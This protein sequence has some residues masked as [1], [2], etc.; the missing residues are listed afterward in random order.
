MS[1]LVHNSTKRV[2]ARLLGRVKE[3]LEAFIAPTDSFSINS[4]APLS[5]CYNLVELNLSLVCSPLPFVRLKKA[6]RHLD[7]LEYL[8]LPT[9]TTILVEESAD[10]PW[11]PRLRHLRLSGSFPKD[12]MEFFSWPERQSSLTLIWCND[13]SVNSISSLIC[14]RHLGRQLKHLEISPENRILQPGSINAVPRF[15]PNLRSLVVPGNLLQDDFFNNL[16][17]TPLSLEYLAIEKSTTIFHSLGFSERSL[18]SALDYGLSNLQSVLFDP[19]YSGF[20]SSGIFNSISDAL[21]AQWKRRSPGEFAS[22]EFE[23]GVFI[24]DRDECSEFVF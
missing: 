22:R 1:W 4:L 17:G 14:S 23:I 6:I 10:M 19:V 9:S 2:T 7:K 3:N 5:K 15:L 21:I 20:K 16:N 12:S 18:I 13:L 11:P 24:A 8:C